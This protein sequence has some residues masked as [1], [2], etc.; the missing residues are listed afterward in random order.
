MTYAHR[1]RARTPH[2]RYPRYP[3][4]PHH[5]FRRKPADFPAAPPT[6]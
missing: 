4:D 3:H 6:P 2:P 1:M 5:P